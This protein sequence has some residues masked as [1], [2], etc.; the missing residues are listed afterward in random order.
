MI[1]RYVIMIMVYIHMSK[2]VNDVIFN[3]FNNSAHIKLLTG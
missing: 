3:N 1:P 2:V